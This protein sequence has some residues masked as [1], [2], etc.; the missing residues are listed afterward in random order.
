[1]SKK[2]VDIR[3]EGSYVFE[4]DL[5]ISGMRVVIPET[6]FKWN[7]ESHTLE[8]CILELS[9][10]AEYITD[11]AGILVLKEST[12]E[13]CVAVDEVKRDG[14]DEAYNFKGTDMEPVLTFFRVALPKGAAALEDLEWKIYR[15]LDRR[16]YGKRSF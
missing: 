2:F 15:V 4:V 1:M 10:D 5:E 13:F 6:V 3:S 12:K 11:V 7:G 9:S 8:S 14:I 16:N